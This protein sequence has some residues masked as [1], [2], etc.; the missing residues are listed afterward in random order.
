MQYLDTPAVIIELEKV[1]K[2]IRKFQEY[3]EKNNCDF[4]PHIK[5]HKMPRFAK[6]QMDYGAC[7]ICCAT[8]GEAEVMAASG[9]TDI[10]VAYTLVGKEKIERFLAL[11]R[12]IRIVCGIDNIIVAS[13]I[14]ELAVAHGQIAELRIEID[15][16][17]KRAGIQLDEIVDFA[18]EAHSLPGVNITGIYT[19]KSSTLGGKATLDLKAAGEEEG[20][21]LHETAQLLRA[22]GIPIKD[23]SGGST[24]TGEY[25]ASCEGV[26]ELRAGTYIFQDR[27]KIIQKVATVDECAAYVKVMV[28]S[29]PTPYRAVIDGG[30]K[31]FSGDTKTDTPPLNMH[32]YGHILEHDHLIFDHMNEEHGVI[33][34]E[35]IPTGLTVGD[36]L[37]IIPNH[38]CTTINLCNYVYIKETDG[39]YSKTA[40][41][42]RGM[43]N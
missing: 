7:G 4:R 27:P 19:F 37:Y 5:T 16:G 6:M 10:F 23:V 42:C 39:T 33:I 21:L 20:K 9:I 17:H 13:E 36:I 28:V 11:G 24:P 40:V 43:V 15:T 14:S 2:N 32:G 31:V 22:S 30:V 38:I 35:K 3:A 12:Q 41:T 8:L 25:V 18:K 29:T 26:T 34:S 1:E